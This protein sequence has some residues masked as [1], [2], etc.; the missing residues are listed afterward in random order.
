MPN[1]KSTEK[2][3]RQN[4]KRRVRNKS[5]KSRMKTA[6]RNVVETIE[7]GENEGAQKTLKEA[8]SIINKTAQKGIIHE[9]KASRLTSRLTRKYNTKFSQ[10]EPSTE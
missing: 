4:E 8:I 10:K 2:R 5:E 1:K 3:L 7:R 9:N 6:I